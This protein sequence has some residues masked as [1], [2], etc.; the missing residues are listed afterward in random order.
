MFAKT[1]AFSDLLTSG[2]LSLQLGLFQNVLEK[3]SMK[4][5][6]IKRSF[7]RNKEAGSNYVVESLP[8]MF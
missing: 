5:I 1:S 3:H 6:K 7:D 4:L 2:A 8:S